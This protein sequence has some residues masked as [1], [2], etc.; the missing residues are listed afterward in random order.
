MVKVYSKNNCMQCKMTKRWLEEHNIDF[1]EA[2]VSLDESA[3]AEARATGYTSMP[4]V[5]KGDQVLCSGFQPSNL[6]T[7]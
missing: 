4:I 6:A 7:L 5:M 2:N 3:M 1:E